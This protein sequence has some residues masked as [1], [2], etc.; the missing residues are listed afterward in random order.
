MIF[1]L[2][3]RKQ[4]RHFF[5]KEAWD[6]KIKWDDKLAKLQFLCWILDQAFIIKAGAESWHFDRNMECLSLSGKEINV[7]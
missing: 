7:E 6:P 3:K 1:I 4:Y 2:I 5:K